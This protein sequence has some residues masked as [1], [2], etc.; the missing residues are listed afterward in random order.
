MERFKRP[1]DPQMYE[2]DLMQMM[3]AQNMAGKAEAA[4]GEQM[5]ANEGVGFVPAEQVV[6]KRMTKERLTKAMKDL[7]DYKAGKAHLESRLIETEQWWKMR[8]GHGCR[9]RARRT[10]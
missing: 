8:T 9:N 6:A 4:P 3:Q 2:P 5:Q 1:V 7:T 10:I